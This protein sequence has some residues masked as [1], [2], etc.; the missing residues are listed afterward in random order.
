MTSI[1]DIDTATIDALKKLRDQ[2]EVL[3]ERLAKMEEKK[4][5][6]SPTVYERV[7]E[8]YRD[9]LRSLDE[10]A[11]PLEERARGEWA[12]LREVFHRIQD[13]Q[14][15][16]RL[17]RE[18]LEFRHELGEFKEGEFEEQVESIEQRLEE[19]EGEIEEMET[20]RQSFVE[21]FGSE[22]RL[23]SGTGTDLPEGPAAAETAEEP[24]LE[25]ETPEEQGAEESGESVGAPE[26]QPS[27]AMT[28]EVA[29]EAEPDR[30]AES[31]EGL[32]P[33][34]VVPPPEP[35]EEPDQEPAGDDVTFVD[36]AP[37]G[38]PTADLPLQEEPDAGAT[39]IMSTPPPPQGGGEDATRILRKPR[40]ETLEGTDVGHSFVLGALP[41]T[42]G[43]SSDNTVH[44]LEEAV[45][46]HHAELIPGPDGFLLRDL[47]SENGTFVNGKRKKEHVL[48]DGDIV[49]IGLR[50]MVF[51][52]T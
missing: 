33:A 17:E 41:L 42:I 34:P 8:D 28:G 32:P 48:A 23:E 37:A 19:H 21:A 2:Q 1:P 24:A 38:S 49:Q 16:A 39:R 20:L 14:A 52:E 5:S 18:E 25:D 36:Q 9:R 44:L 45:S 50:K 46:R 26:T 7:H 13:L 43:R 4:E 47:G 31:L 22:E 30:P 29:T 3:E 51:K 15:E 6:V 12:R 10:E 35:P 27:T 40:L 11:R